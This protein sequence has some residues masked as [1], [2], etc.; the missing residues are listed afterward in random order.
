MYLYERPNL[1]V[2]L[3][4]VDP[5][6]QNILWTGSSPWDWWNPS[7]E[8][9]DGEIKVIGMMT[10]V[11]KFVNDMYQLNSPEENSSWV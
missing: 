11:L 4:Q 6:D 2:P 10:N 9:S 7:N 5:A 3:C 8:N 1:D